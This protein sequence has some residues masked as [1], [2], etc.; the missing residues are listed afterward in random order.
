MSESWSLGRIFQPSSRFELTSHPGGAAVGS[1]LTR[2]DTVKQ[3]QGSSFRERHVGK[4]EQAGRAGRPVDRLGPSSRSV[5]TPRLGW[6]RSRR[7]EPGSPELA[8]KHTAAWTRCD[9]WPC[10]AR[11]NVDLVLQQESLFKAQR[12][13]EADNSTSSRAGLV[14]APSRRFQPNRVR[15]QTKRCLLG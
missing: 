4:T 2:R 9:L 8:Q 3:V 12:Q 6:R 11:G 10:R 1:F 7:V 15:T 13:R 5:L 14:C